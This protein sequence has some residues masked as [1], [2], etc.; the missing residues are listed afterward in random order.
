MICFSKYVCNC[1]T[2][3]G[4]SNRFGSDRRG[5]YVT[6][7]RWRGNEK[8][9]KGFGEEKGPGGNLREKNW[10]LSKLRPFAKNFYQ[11]HPAVENR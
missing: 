7:D 4:G 8:R 2:F 9:I 1:R 6:G 10:D 3:K 11:P 5:G